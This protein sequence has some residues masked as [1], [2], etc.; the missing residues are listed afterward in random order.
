MRKPDIPY[1][2]HIETDLSKAL[3]GVI[4]KAAPTVSDVADLLKA[5]SE[6][7]M[8]TSMGQP[9]NLD[10]AVTKSKLSEAAEELLAMHPRLSMEDSVVDLK[11][12]EGKLST[13]DLRQIWPID[14]SRFALIQYYLIAH[15]AVDFD[16]N[17]AVS[18]IGA[19][20]KEMGVKVGK[21]KGM[22]LVEFRPAL[23]RIRQFTK[24]VDLEQDILVFTLQGDRTELDAHFNKSSHLGKQVNDVADYLSSILLS[25]YEEGGLALEYGKKGNIKKLKMIPSL[26]LLKALY[27][28]KCFD[29]A[30]QAKEFCEKLLGRLGVNLDWNRKIQN[31]KKHSDPLHGFG[32]DGFVQ[33]KRLEQILL[34]LS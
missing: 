12:L 5:V 27:E 24:V 31:Y 26:F 3:F 19:K 13:F 21:D 2:D 16:L 14:S 10:V 8:H 28:K 34:L 30:G 11:E 20:L 17:Q 9:L 6:R 15:M 25:L 23:D 32:L 7:L 4:K 1:L 22:R 29:S 18:A 33:L